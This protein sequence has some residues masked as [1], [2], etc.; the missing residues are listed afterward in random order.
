MN[1]KTSRFN[2]CSSCTL[3]VGIYMFLRNWRR[4]KYTETSLLEGT[5]D[6]R[7]LVSSDSQGR[8]SCYCAGELDLVY[9]QQS[10]AEVHTNQSP[11]TDKFAKAAFNSPVP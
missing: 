4:R 5:T 6:R 1:K 2:T 3:H 8:L 10:S 7:V 11:L 9:L